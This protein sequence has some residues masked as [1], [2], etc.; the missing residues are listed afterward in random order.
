MNRESRRCP[1]RISGMAHITVGWN[2]QTYMIR[3]RTAIVSRGMTPGTGIRCIIIIT[4]MTG[5][6][7]AGNT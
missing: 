4:V 3:I 7:I 2:T 6:T 1:I 5:I